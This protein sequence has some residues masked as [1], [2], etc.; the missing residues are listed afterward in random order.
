MKFAKELD[1]DLGTWLDGHLETSQWLITYAV[2]E[3]RAKYFDYKVRDR[4]ET[5]RRL[6]NAHSIAH[7]QERKRSKQ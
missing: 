7:R 3:W 2:P 6:P 4:N 1:E 5:H